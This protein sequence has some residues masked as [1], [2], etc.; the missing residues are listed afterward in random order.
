MGP[1]DPLFQ[2]FRIKS[3]ELKNRIVYPPAVSVT[4]IVTPEGIAWYDRI[5]R[6]GVGAI[7]VESARLA[8]FHDS[9][10][11][12]NLPRLADTIHQHDVLAAIQLF[13]P[14]QTPGGDSVSVSGTAD[15]RAVTPEELQDVAA[16]FAHA[17]TVALDAGFDGVEPHGAH[18]FF[19]NQFFSPLSNTRNDSYGGSIENRTRLGVEVVEAVRKAAGPDHLVFYRHTPEQREE[20]GYGLEDSLQFAPRLESA[21]VD[22]LD[23]SPSTHNVTPREKFDPVGPHAGLAEAF[24]NVVECPIIAVGGMNDPAAAVRV[25]ERGKVD[26]LAI[27]RGLIADAEWPT[28]VAEGRLDEIIECVECNE[29]CYGNL[30]RGEQIACTQWP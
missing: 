29:F 12:A 22:V 24:R 1:F 9:D 16:D 17:T 6:G 28:K 5:A 8:C 15:V 25:L 14:P 4:G 13:Q 3:Y 23:I 20:G 10:F 21:G 27:C 30:F 26:L 7:I 2:P 18:G 19:L 11:V